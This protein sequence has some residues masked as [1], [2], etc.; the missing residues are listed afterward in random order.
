M[1]E[2]KR[3]RGRPRKNP[4]P[5]EV[6]NAVGNDVITEVIGT[7]LSAVPQEAIDGF[8][9]VV[10]D[11]IEETVV[12]KSFYKWDFTLDDKIEY[13]D[14]E[15]TYEATGYRPIT[16]TESLDFNPEW[17][18]EMARLKSETGKYY[19]GKI[20][21]KRYYDFWK[22]EM[23]RCNEGYTVNGYTLTGD[24]YF[25]LNYYRLQDIQNVKVAGTGRTVAFPSFFAKQYEYFHY[26][27]LC[28]ILKKDVLALKA[29]GV[30]FSEIGAAL[31]VRVYSTVP[32]MH[33]IYTAFGETHLDG[34]L[35]KCWK[36]LEYLNKETE[37][38]MKHLRQRY[39][40]DRHKR[41]SLLNKQREESGWMSE[42]VGILCDNP[43]KLRGDR[44]DRLFF[45]EA[46][47]NPHLMKTYIQSAPLVEIMGTKFGTRFVWG[48]GGDTGEALGGLKKLFYNP[49]GY[50]GLPYRHKYTKSGEYVE[51]AFFIPSY[52]FLG[53][54][55]DAESD[56]LNMKIGRA[57]V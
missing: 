33:V 31:G 34:V 23:R 26:I 30:G 39:N 5:Q 27:G 54:P 42:I 8:K 17:F 4:V 15:K 20:G 14:P 43:R 12:R 6:V 24:N 50:G 28:E 44:G 11:Y 19:H 29:R 55:D 47:S 16:E 36:Q 21:N 56:E 35:K 48:T 49:K 51:T 40:S 37:G 13:F 45:E 7:G 25:F 2:E 52:T 10:K 53:K 22:E 1:A 3:K 57:H 18:T 9:T 41:A 38:G 32:D 46:G